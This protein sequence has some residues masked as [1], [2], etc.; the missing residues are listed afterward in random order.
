MD[1]NFSDH[2]ETKGLRECTVSDFIVDC[3]FLAETQ[4]SEF[5]AQISELESTVLQLQ[6]REFCKTNDC[7]ILTS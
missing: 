7:V 2:A 5:L 1:A 4:K 3:I 6:G